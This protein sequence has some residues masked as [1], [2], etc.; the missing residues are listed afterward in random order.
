MC[1]LCGGIFANPF[2]GHLG[3]GLGDVNHIKVG[4]VQYGLKSETLFGFNINAEGYYSI[5]S[6]YNTGI[7]LGWNNF[8]GIPIGGHTTVLDIYKVQ[9]Q[10]QFRKKILVNSTFLG[11]FALGGSLLDQTLIKP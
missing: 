5:S 9:L 2:Q 4:E 11:E 6:L 7:L 8:S 1:M 3:L 10:N